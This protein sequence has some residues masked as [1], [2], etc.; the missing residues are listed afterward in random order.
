MAAHTEPELVVAC[1][2][3]RLRNK[4]QARVN[5]RTIAHWNFLGIFTAP[6][7]PDTSG[8]MRQRLTA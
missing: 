2:C 3:T 4:N 8:Q 7:A 1:P 5:H 6:G